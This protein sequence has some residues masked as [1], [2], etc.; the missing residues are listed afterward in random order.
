[1]RFTA[2]YFNIGG[3]HGRDLLWVVRKQPD[4]LDAQDIKDAS[5]NK[6]ISFISIPTQG[7][8]GVQRV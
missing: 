8:I 7:L 1:M 2:S 6:E 5:A 3:N 4:S